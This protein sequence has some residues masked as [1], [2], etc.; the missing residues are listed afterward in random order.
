MDSNFQYAEAVK[1]LVGAF[2]CVDCLGRVGAPVGV[3][4][5]R[6]FFI[7]S[8]DGTPQFGAFSVRLIQRRNVVISQRRPRSTSDDKWLSNF[9]PA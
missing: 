1:L 8:G 5:L 3:L 6:S 2:S 9:I 7:V 4:R